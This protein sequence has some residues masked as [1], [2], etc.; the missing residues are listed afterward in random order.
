M[1]APTLV[2]SILAAIGGEATA[3]ATS[4]ATW[5]GHLFRDEEGR[6]RI[7][8]P[9][10]AMGVMA[11]A[12]HV[13]AGGLAKKLAPFVSPVAGDYVFWNY[14]L[15]EPG[16]PAARKLPT[17]LV[18]IRGPVESEETE[19]ETSAGV[20][21]TMSEGK[22]LE[23]EPIDPEW[24]RA[25]AVFFRDAASPFRVARQLDES[26]AAVARFAREALAALQK[27][28]AVPA[29][30]A[31]R[32]E[33]LATAEPEAR[34]VS[35][36]RV[37]TERDIQRWLSQLAAKGTALPGLE[38]LPPLPPSTVELQRLFLASKDKAAFLAAVRAIFPEPG[39][40]SSIDLVHYE[41]DGRGSTWYATAALDLVRDE[42][43]EAAFARRLAATR[44]VLGRR[45]GR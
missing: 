40:L 21:A 14:E 37:R 11:R 45:D 7:G 16:D 26:D 23:F 3:S 42:W 12:P 15:E 32:Y 31:T 41:S 5:E 25:W 1:L 30:S 20:L 36:F 27:M 17:V 13:V 8:W 19:R 38:K 44:E 18:R 28:R 34:I 24:V 35:R 4:V 22:L 43:D 2:I 29:P 39:D 9:V 10:V 6:M 33:A